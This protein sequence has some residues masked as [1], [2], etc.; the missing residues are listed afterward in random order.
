MIN[1]CFPLHVD[2]VLASK[3]LIFSDYTK[4]IFQKGNL[5]PDK[6]VHIKPLMSGLIKVY[7][8][9]YSTWMSILFDDTTV[10]PFVFDAVQ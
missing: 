9:L 5:F 6:I 10:S 2:G 1:M 3:W 7:L 8:Q 4:Q